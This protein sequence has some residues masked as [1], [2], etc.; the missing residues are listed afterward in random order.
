[1]NAWWA[2]EILRIETGEHV[3]RGT[4]ED[5][6]AKCKVIWRISRSREDVAGDAEV[7]VA[8]LDEYL[9]FEELSL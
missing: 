1:M 8:N 2:K 6:E 9:G 7:L 4:K 5:C 3:T